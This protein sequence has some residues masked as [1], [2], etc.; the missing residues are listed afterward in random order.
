[1]TTFEKLENWALHTNDISELRNAF[2]EVIANNRVNEIDIYNDHKKSI[3]KTMETAKETN[4]FDILE[5]KYP[6]EFKK[7]YKKLSYQ[8]LYH[9]AEI[10]LEVLEGKRDFGDP[11]SNSSRWANNF[12]NWLELENKM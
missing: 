4:T 5:A 2:I 11:M 12:I 6:K 9:E 10:L 8:M 1:M 3:D 7:V